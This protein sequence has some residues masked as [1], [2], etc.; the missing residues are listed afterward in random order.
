MNIVNFTKCGL[1]AAILIAVS[2]GA[3]T[4][5]AAAVTNITSC[6]TITQSGYSS[7]CKISSLLLAVFRTT[8]YKYKPTLS[9]STSMAIRSEEREEWAMASQT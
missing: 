7:L 9:M 8:A 2:L 6:T 1:L 4:T 3:Y 5:E